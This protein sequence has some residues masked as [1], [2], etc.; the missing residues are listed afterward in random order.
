MSFSIRPYRQ[1]P[2]V[3]ARNLPL[4]SVPVP[5]NARSFNLTIFMEGYHA[6]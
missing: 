3:L 4:G 6:K 2:L 5:R 1:F